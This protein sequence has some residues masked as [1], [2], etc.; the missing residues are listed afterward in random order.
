MRATGETVNLVKLRTWLGE[1]GVHFPRGGKHA[2]IM[3][4]WLEKA[5]ILSGCRVDE[6]RFPTILGVPTEEAEVPVR[7]GGNKAPVG[8]M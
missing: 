3:R 2:S 8:W 5:G 4:L 1:C 7:F 6:E